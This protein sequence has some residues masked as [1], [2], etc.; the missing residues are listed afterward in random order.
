MPLSGLLILYVPL[1]IDDGLG[2]P[3]S[4]SLYVWFLRVLLQRLHIVDLGPCSKFLSILIICDHINHKIWLSSHVYVSELLDEWNLASCKTASTPFPSG[5]TPL[6]SAPPNLL[7]DVSDA[8]LVPCYQ[9]LVGCLLYLA[10]ATWLDISYYA[11]WLGQ[12]NATPTQ[13]HF[14]A[15]KHVLC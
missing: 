9:Q 4:T 1:H 10:I 12:F 15:A 2:I 5:L 13:A 7:P 8:E 11:M 3:N 6:I 14:L